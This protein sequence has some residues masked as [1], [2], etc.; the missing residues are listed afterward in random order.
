MTLPEAAHTLPCMTAVVHEPI[1]FRA[2]FEALIA[3]TNGLL[4]T[5]ARRPADMCFQLAASRERPYEFM[6]CLLDLIR[7]LYEPNPPGTL[8]LNSNWDLFAEAVPD[9]RFKL[10]YVTVTGA[11][12]QELQS[13]LDQRLQPRMRELGQDLRSADAAFICGAVGP[14]L[15]K[16][17]SRFMSGVCEAFDAGWKVG[18]LMEAFEA[19]ASGDDAP[20]GPSVLAGAALDEGLA[21][22]QIRLSLWLFSSGS[23]VAK[24]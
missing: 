21:G 4:Q 7:V 12:G 20:A 9:K 3:S 24:H 10:D 6:Q 22:R 19:T 11:P 15:W 23:P 14:E 18:T 5:T 16:T 2:F 17:S 13:L 8:H 1:Q